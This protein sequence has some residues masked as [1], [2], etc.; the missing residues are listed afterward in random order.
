MLGKGE[1]CLRTTDFGPLADRPFLAV[2]NLEETCHKGDVVT[3]D[4]LYENLLSEVRGLPISIGKHSSMSGIWISV[5][6]NDRHKVRELILYEGDDG[7]FH[8]A[9]Q[10]IEYAGAPRL[11][12]ALSNIIPYFP[13]RLFVKRSEACDL[14]AYDSDVHDAVVTR[15]LHE[16]INS[17]L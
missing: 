1:N 13:L 12:I 9:L 7:R 6:S 2:F 4:G 17:Y 11:I 3:I 8:L 10:S 15:D 16:L 14:K 5:A